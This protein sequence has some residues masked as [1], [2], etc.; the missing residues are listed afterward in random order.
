MHLSVYLF[1]QLSI[2]LSTHALIWSLTLLAIFRSSDLCVH[3]LDFC[4]QHQKTKQFCDTFSLFAVENIT[5]EAILRDFLQ[6][7]KVDCTADG[8]VPMRFALF[9]AMSLKYCACHEKVSPG[10]TKCC[11]CHEKASWHS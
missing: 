6:K 4:W 1:F 5:N 8:L 3:L 11:T 9:H 7:W 2:H 10:H